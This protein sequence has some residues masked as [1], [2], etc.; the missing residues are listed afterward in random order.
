MNESKLL[1]RVIEAADMVGI[2]R[3][4]AYAMVR[5]G[6]WPSVRIGKSVRVPYKWLVT[7]VEEE[8]A[9]AEENMLTVP[10]RAL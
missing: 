4:K 8:T 2:G 1:L 7:W 10:Y 3:S 6:A 5:E 9:A